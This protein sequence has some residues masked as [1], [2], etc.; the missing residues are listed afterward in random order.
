M[1]LSAA[2]S[3]SAIFPVPSG[4]LSSTMS[5][6]ALGTVDRTRAVMR[7]ILSLSL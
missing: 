6:S 1:C 3:S 5:K 4:L 7:R 2:A